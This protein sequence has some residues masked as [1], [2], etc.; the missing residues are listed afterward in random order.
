MDSTNIPQFQ[1]YSA[2]AVKEIIK[3]NRDLN[4][5]IKDDIVPVFETSVPVRDLLQQFWIVFNM[6]HCLPGV[7]Q[8]RSVQ[9]DN[10]DFISPSAKGRSS[11]TDDINMTFQKK[12]L[13]AVVIGLFVDYYSDKLFWSCTIQ[14]QE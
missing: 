11:I 9:N 4:A 12:G 7:Y 5:A 2:S 14:V 13:K 3:R 8:A 10:G 1:Q 6:H